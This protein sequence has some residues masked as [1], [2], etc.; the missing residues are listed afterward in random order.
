M[1][2]T[3]TLSLIPET[4]KKTF[5]KIQKLHRKLSKART[6]VLFNDICLQENIYIYI[7]ICTIC[8]PTYHSSTS[9][10]F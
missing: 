2:I 1:N 3:E 6:A 7:Y 8:A 9:H 5:N 4:T 10:L